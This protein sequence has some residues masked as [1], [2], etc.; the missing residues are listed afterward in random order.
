[1]RRQ[2]DGQRSGQCGRVGIRRLAEGQD[3]G[4]WA[5]GQ[6]IGLRLGQRRIG[7]GGAAHRLRRVVDED[8]QRALRGEVVGEG[9]HLGGI[10]QVDADDA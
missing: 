6:R 7:A 9:D 1:M 10:T 8:V 3:L 5:G 4:A 2:V